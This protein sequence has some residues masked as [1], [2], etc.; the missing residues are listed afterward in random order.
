MDTDFR[1]DFL[2]HCAALAFH[3][4]I[5]L[6]PNS[7]A[8]NKKARVVTLDFLTSCLIERST[9]DYINVIQQFST[10]ENFFRTV[11]REMMRSGALQR[12]QSWNYEIMTV[13]TYYDDKRYQHRYF[14]KLT[15]QLS[16]DTLLFVFYKKEDKRRFEH[17]RALLK[18]KPKKTDHESFNKHSNLI[19][20]PAS[21]EILE[22]CQSYSPTELFFTQANTL[23]KRLQKL[24]DQ[25]WPDMNYKVVIFGYIYIFIQIFYL[26]INIYICMYK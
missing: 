9:Y 22:L 26:Y 3:D 25:V 14:S 24:I 7:N 8:N 13:S 16:N 11:G 6:D 20:D 15:E 10:T 5:T 2:D 18:K 23:V 12:W 1:I 4:S 21:R 17:E 19:A